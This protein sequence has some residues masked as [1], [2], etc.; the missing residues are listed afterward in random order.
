MNKVSGVLML[1]I[2]VFVATAL[3]ASENFVQ[4][5]NLQNVLRWSSYFAI[6]GIGA[7][8]VI[9]TGGIEL[10]IGS[11]LA[12]AGCSLPLL[13]VQA[14]WTPAAAFAVAMGI[15]LLVGLYDGLLITKVKLPPFIVT[16]CG[17]MICRGL[18]R[19]LT[20]DKSQ[21]FGQTYDDSFRLIATGKPCSLALL[22]VFVGCVTA[23]WFFASWIRLRN[24]QSVNQRPAEALCGVLGGLV[25]AIVGSSRFWQGYEITSGG[26]IELLFGLKMSTWR[27]TVSAD[28]MRLP[29]ELMW[30]CGLAMIPAGIWFTV[31]ALRKDPKIFL[32][33]LI[34]QIVALVVFLPLAIRGCGDWFSLEEP[35]DRRWRMTEVFLSL[36]VVMASLAWFLKSGLRAGQ[37]AARIPAILTVGTAIMWLVGRS[38][39]LRGRLEDNGFHEAWLTLAGKTRLLEILVPM[40]MLIMLVLAITVSIFLN[41]TIYGRYLFA[42][43]RNEQAARYSGINTDAMIMLAYL[44]CGAITGLAAILFMLELNSLEPS[45][46]GNTYELYAIA[47]A[48]LGGCSLKGGEGSILG[49]VLGA[50]VMYL[51]RNSISLLGIPSPLEYTI[52]GVVIL[53]GVIV[54]EMVK[55]IAFRRRRSIEASNT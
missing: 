48:V 29:G 24:S 21:G 52:I 9:I 50:G 3:L 13:I 17:L 35:W 4:P 45:N 8:I 32:K 39:F 14:Q 36:A 38:Y 41:A 34:L 16:L 28:A 22:L 10:S 15:A 11:V 46:H 25:L 47:A 42:L 44:L 33:P 55:R 19:W 40:P 23:I 1:L 12:L 30:W 53:A 6:I 37:V 54:D 51:L 18:A 26:E 43:G 20:G 31:V 5:Y 7:A 27:A 2:Y 49:V